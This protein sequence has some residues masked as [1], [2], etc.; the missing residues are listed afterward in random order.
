VRRL[1]PVL[2]AL[3]ALVAVAAAAAKPGAQW[4]NAD[5]RLVTERGLLGGDAARFR[6]SDPITRGELDEL[7]AGLTGAEQPPAAN[8]A[9]PLDL[10]GLDAR[11]VNGLGLKGTASRFVRSAKAAGLAPPARFGTEVAARLLGLR[12]NHPAKDDVL[13][14]LPADP[15]PR[16]EA[17]CS[18]AQILRFGGWE[19]DAVRAAAQEFVIP[20]LTVWQRRILAAALQRVGYPYIWGGTSDGRQSLFGVTVPGGYDCSGFVWRVYKLERYAGGDALPATLRGRTTYAMSGEV[21]RARRIGLLQLQPADVLFF[22]DKG[23]ESKPAQVGH[24]G[25]YVGNGWFVHSSGRGVALQRLAGWYQ[26]RFAWARRPLAEAGL[27]SG[28]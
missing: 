12:L 20:P 9:A 25:I 5:I 2:A 6:P 4:A 24:M 22:G 28:K 1:L 13:E 16:A 14:P 21:P 8:A 26:T 7:L 27:A 15:A 18:A 19:L 3:L 11:L 23:A 17:A 10:Q